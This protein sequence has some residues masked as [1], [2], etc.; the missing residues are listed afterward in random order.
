V[1]P[2]IETAAARAVEEAE[3]LGIKGGVLMDLCREDRELGFELYRALAEVIMAR[4]IATRLQLLD[5]FAVG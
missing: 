3:V 5:V 2:R 4:M 1:E